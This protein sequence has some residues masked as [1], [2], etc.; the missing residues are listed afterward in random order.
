MTPYL[1][2]L[3]IIRTLQ[4]GIKAVIWTDAFQA[5]CMTGGMA[6]VA[7]QVSKS[8]NNIKP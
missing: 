6:A 4:G 7:I 5:V 3:Y 2:T 8:G 1:R